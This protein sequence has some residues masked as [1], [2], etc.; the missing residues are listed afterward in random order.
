[1]PITMITTHTAR[2]HLLGGTAAAALLL[3]VASP[4]TAQDGIVA[5]APVSAGVTAIAHA[6]DNADYA[7]ENTDILVTGVRDGYTVAATSSATKTDTPIIDVPQSIAIITAQQ[8][9][10]QAIRSVA[11]LVRLVPGVSPAQGEGNR[12]Q[13]ILRGNN[14]T[15]DF[16]TDGLRDD[17]QQFRSFYNVERV[18]VLKGSN[19]MIFGRGGGGGVINR[20]LKGPDANDAFA[21]ANVSLDSFGAWYGSMDINQPLSDSAAVRINGLYEELNNHRDVFSGDRWAINPTLAFGLGAS[22]ILIGY[23]HAEDDR[24]TDRGVPS[25]NGV[26]ID[27]FDRT[28]FG[29]EGVNRAGFNGD[30]LRL[31]TIHDLSDTLSL[32]TNVT[33]GD[34]A[35]YYRNVFVA[36]AVRTVAGAPVVDVQ[37]YEDR[38]SRETLIAQANLT[39]RTQVAGMDHVLLFGVEASRQD[40]ISERING[41]FG[42]AGTT[43]ANRTATVT[44]ADPFIVP[45]A[46]FVAGVIGNSNRA[47]TSQLDQISVYAQDQVSLTDQLQ[48]IAGL[49]YDRFALDVTNVFTAASFRRVD[50]LWSPRVGLVF[51]PTQDSSLYASWSR[52]YLPQSGDQFSSLDATLATLEPESFDNYEVGA[53]WDVTP[54][55]FVTAA[56]YILDRSNTRAAGPIPGTIVLTGRQRSKGVEFSATGR[57]LPHW[58]VSAGYAYTDARVLEGDTAGRRVAQVPRH[59]LSLWNRYEATDRLGVGLGLIHQSRSFANISNAVVLPSFNRVDGALFFQLAD[60]VE[61][62]LNVENLLGEDYYASAHTDNNISPGAPTTVRLTVKFDF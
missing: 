56:A 37:A 21:L 57:I 19:A 8:I 6:D 17:V 30:V 38:N 16:F 55:L 24:V 4:A 41:F 50:D 34:Y 33:Y 13:V 9:D 52:S 47:S 43:A 28:F 35:K 40:S 11:D 5:G 1:M 45:T 60:G 51:K 42:A 3:V 2:I 46:R 23:E 62:Q 58:Q 15:A 36:T 53:K 61:T 48:L 59:T 49:R 32:S 18:E 31:R 27:G 10:D 20:V 29:A 7:G 25:I 44:L 12:D 54:S 26:P 22:R 39:W 14:S